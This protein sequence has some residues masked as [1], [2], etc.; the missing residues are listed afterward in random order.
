MAVPQALWPVWGGALGAATLAYH[1]RRQGN[2]ER[3]GV[4]VE[5]LEQVRPGS[6]KDDAHPPG[7]NP[8]L[9]SRIALPA[10]CR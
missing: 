9:A 4:A 3:N 8:T 6:T 10:P 5:P 1:F 7:C 2:T